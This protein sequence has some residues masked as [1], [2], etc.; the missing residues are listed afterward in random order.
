MIDSPGRSRRV[1]AAGNDIHYLEWGDP[2]ND[3][4]MVLLHG[5]LGHA[6]WWDFIAPW[7]A[8]QYRVI[9][10]DFGGMGESGPREAYS[11]AGFIAEIGGLLQALAVK[12][13]TL[14]G[15]SLGGCI[16]IF[17]CRDYPQYIER[18]I[19]I[20]SKLGFPDSPMRPRMTP[21]SKRL[22]PDLAAALSRFRLMPQEPAT[23]PA[24]L[25]HIARHSIK[26]EGNHFLWKFDERLRHGVDWTGA[27]EGEAFAQITLPIDFV[28]GEFSAVVPAELAERVG[29]AIRNGRGPIVIPSAYHHIPI[30]QPLALTAVL[31]ALLA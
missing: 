12:P 31:R 7:F 20:D 23:P 11:S 9:A 2:D 29:K 17:A 28:C 26:Q 10:M 14:I 6:H 1:G 4:V 13:V 25:A 8:R 30:G 21:R 5:F 27:T 16:A 19:V 22:Y 24:V 3:R 18:A 15:H